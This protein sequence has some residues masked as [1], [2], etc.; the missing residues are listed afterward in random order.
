[1]LDA[2]GQS[3]SETVRLSP[4]HRLKVAALRRPICM[5]F[6]IPSMLSGICGTC[7]VGVQASLQLQCTHRRCRKRNQPAMASVRAVGRETEYSSRD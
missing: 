3:K 5:I 4:A 6:F 2:V 7:M 1:M